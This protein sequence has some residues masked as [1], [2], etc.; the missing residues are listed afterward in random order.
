MIPKSTKF[1]LAFALQVI[2]ILALIIVKLSVLE[3]GTEVF[4]RIAPVDPRDP[5]RGDFVSFQYDI[6]RVKSYQIRDELNN[7]QNVRNGDDL[8]VVL[9]EGSPYWYVREARR[10]V[11]VP[12]SNEKLV[13]IKGRVISGGQDPYAQSPS[14]LE[15]STTTLNKNL[16]LESKELRLSYGI[17][18]YY[19]PE[20]A[21]NNF[22]FWNKDAGMRVKVDERGNAVPTQ[23]YV[24]GKAWPTS[25]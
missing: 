2:I 21:G 25:K 14:T 18:Q 5:L 10:G 16:S 3:G 8:Y 13:F 19:I 11:P 20:G 6:S 24:D 23:L 17:E 15:N 22:S 4:L 7:S 1:I 9:E 12:D